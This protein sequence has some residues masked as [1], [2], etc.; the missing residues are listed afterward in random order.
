M[1]FPIRRHWLLGSQH[2]IDTTYGCVVRCCLVVLRVCLGFLCYLAH[3]GDKAVERLLAFVLSGLNHEAFMEEE[4]E[5][6]GRS[7]VAIVEQTLGNIH[8]GDTS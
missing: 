7:M 6:D 1:K 8:C 2:V 3:H 4:R 5:V